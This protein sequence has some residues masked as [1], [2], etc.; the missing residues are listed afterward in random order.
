MYPIHRSTLS[1]LALSVLIPL[2]GCSKQSDPPKPQPPVT[3]NQSGPAATSSAPARG[4]FGGGSLR[5]RQ[6]ASPASPASAP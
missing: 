5:R 1:L 3:V 6:P 4:S 2:A